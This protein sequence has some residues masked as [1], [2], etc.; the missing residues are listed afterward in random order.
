MSLHRDKLKDAIV[1]VAAHPK[2]RDL[3]LT[4]LYKLLYF[5]DAAH[6]RERGESI[7]GSE[8]IKYQH[9]PVPS[10]GEKLLRNLRREARVEVEKVPYGG[11]EMMSVRVTASPVWPSLTAGEIETLDAICSDLGADKAATLS[12]KSHAEPA[13]V[14]AAMLEKLSEE[15]MMYGAAEDPDGL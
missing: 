11:V 6:L 9:G 7:T 5:A 2:V 3:G 13:W 15:L 10:R 8:Y 14:A 1:F 4:K 12:H